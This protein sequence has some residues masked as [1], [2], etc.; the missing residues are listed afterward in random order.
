M[1]HRTRP[2]LNA[3]IYEEATSW[4]VESRAGD[5][6]D[7][8]RRELDEW[9]RR[10]PEH[11][12]AYLEI[13]AIWN[14][15]PTLDPDGKYNTEALVQ[16]ACGSENVVPMPSVGGFAGSESRAE[17]RL[18]RASKAQ[19]SPYDAPTGEIS[20]SGHRGQGLVAIAASVLLGVV[21]AAAWYWITKN[22]YSTDLGEQRSIVL[23]DGSVIDLNS[24]SQVRVRY[25]ERERDVDLLEGQALFRVAKDTARPFIVSADGTRVRAVGTEFDV[26]KKHIGTVVTVVE[27]RVA[28]STG[29][30][31]AATTDAADTGAENTQG[32]A[33]ARTDTHALGV[34]GG[35]RGVVAGD[36]EV[37]VAAG[38]QLTVTRKATQRTEHP[39]IA[40]ATAW[41][42]RQL[43]FDSATLTE[44]A[45]E[46]NRYNQRQLI[47][48]DPNLYEFHISG[49]FS[50][51]DPSSLIRFLRTRPGVRVVE[52]SERI[53]VSAR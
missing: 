2:K 17:E 6:D 35:G 42:Q 16:Q 25:T 5:L 27:G 43:V 22:T 51:T 12:G 45:E 15:G 44:V 49:V 3:Q 24:R 7:A 39:N 30:A 18:E 50:S 47:V 46:F 32:S 23:A 13:A 38:E 26:Y 37:L 20:S 21:G 40:S 29:S 10:S 41:T 28:V 33:E 48:Q 31:V 53:D 1:E 36:G 34:G 8:G 9:L 14:E 4:F 11:L 19:Q 52:S